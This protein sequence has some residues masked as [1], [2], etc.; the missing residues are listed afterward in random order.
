MGAEKEKGKIQV[1]QE[2]SATEEGPQ[3]RRYGSRKFEFRGHNSLGEGR[4]GQL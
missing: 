3:K 2:R 1:R 4:S